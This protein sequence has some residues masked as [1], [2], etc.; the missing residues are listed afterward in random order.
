MT[1]P[2]QSPG[3][4]GA[5]PARPAATLT[6]SRSSIL[7]SPTKS[8]GTS[9]RCGRLM[10]VAFAEGAGKG[11]Y[12]WMDRMNGAIKSPLEQVK[13]MGA[14]A[15]WL[16][17]RCGRAGGSPVVNYFPASTSATTRRIQAICQAMERP[18]VSP[19]GSVLPARSPFPHDIEATAKLVRMRSMKSRCRVGAE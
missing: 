7:T 18:G 19:A 4:R 2:V 8:S 6:P 11:T 3:H 13:K 14:R 17:L 16:L 12:G 1:D 15:I 10:R 9:H 5:G